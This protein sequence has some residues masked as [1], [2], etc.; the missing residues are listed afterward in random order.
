[1][2]I[3]RGTG[4]GGFHNYASAESFRQQRNLDVAKNAADVNRIMSGGTTGNNQSAASVFASATQPAGAGNSIGP[5]S[6][7]AAFTGTLTPQQSSALRTYYNP[8]LWNSISGTD[9]FATGGLGAGGGMGGAGGGTLSGSTVNYDTMGKERLAAQNALDLSILSQQGRQT[10][11]DKILPLLSTAFGAVS[12]GSIGGQQPTIN[13]GQIY[14]PQ[15][16]QQAVNRGVAG[17]DS[18]FAGL[19]RTLAGRFG[20]AGMSP[21]SG[22]L[23]AL[24]ANAGAQNIAQ[25]ANVRTQVPFDMATGNASHLLNS[26]VAQEGQ[27]ANRQQETLAAQRNAVAMLSAAL[28][29]I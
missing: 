18:R 6:F 15:Q 17:N 23:A 11:L 26:Q 28:G 19:L 12:G 25:N 3:Y 22:L 1:V 10:S 20:A 27:F 24:T 14:T 5:E 8:S 21:D 7:K 13:A 9:E 16:I 4:S 29:I 2:S